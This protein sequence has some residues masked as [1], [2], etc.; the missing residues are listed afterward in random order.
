VPSGW[1]QL[2][3]LGDA[4]L[5]RLAERGLCP[6][7]SGKPVDLEALRCHL[8]AV[9][10]CGYAIGGDWLPGVDGIAVAILDS[11]SRP[12][13]SISAIAF[14]GQLPAARVPEMA[15]AMRRAAD[16]VAAQLGNAASG[17]RA[18]PRLVPPPDGS[19]HLPPRFP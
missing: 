18:G 6:T 13:A 5:D 10:E 12:I 15:A 2:A 17:T 8:K 9:R 14:A 7:G 19:E 3:Y 16:E 1:I 4:E 11:D